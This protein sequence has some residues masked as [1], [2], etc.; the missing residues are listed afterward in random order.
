MLLPHTA[1]YNVVSRDAV[2]VDA[3]WTDYDFVFGLSC[4][5]RQNQT[6]CTVVEGDGEVEGHT[7][8]TETPCLL[9][10]TFNSVHRLGCRKPLWSNLGPP[11]AG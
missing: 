9:F 3:S 11:H 8:C 5:L 7:S 2:T 4:S 6:G 10:C 1:A